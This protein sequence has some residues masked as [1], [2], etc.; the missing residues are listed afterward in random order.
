VRAVDLP[1][2]YS[3]VRPVEDERVSLD[4]VLNGRRRLW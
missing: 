1:G 4:F 3:P 2:I